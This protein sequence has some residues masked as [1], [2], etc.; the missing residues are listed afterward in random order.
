MPGRHVLPRRE[1]SAEA[2]GHPVGGYGETQGAKSAVNIQFAPIV[3]DLVVRLTSV[4]R[5]ARLLQ[6][7]YAERESIDVQ[8]DVEDECALAG[9]AYPHLRGSD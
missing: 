1:R 7:N 2:G 5:S 4:V 3:L 9:R 8:D 6:L